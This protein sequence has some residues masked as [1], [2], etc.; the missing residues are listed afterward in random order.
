MSLSDLVCFKVAS[1]LLI[2]VIARV[3]QSTLL[4]SLSGWCS[5][6][7]YVLG[8]HM[9]FASY[10]TEANALQHVAPADCKVA[11][12]CQALDCC[13]QSGHHNCCLLGV[14]ANHNLNICCILAIVNACL[15]VARLW[16]LPN[17]LRIAISIRT[18]L[19]LVVPHAYMLLQ[20]LQAC[21][22]VATISYMLLQARQE[23]FGYKGTRWSHVSYLLL[24]ICSGG[25]LCLA[26]I[27][28]PQTQVWFLSQ[29]P[30]SEAE[31]VLV[32]VLPA[33]KVVFH[34]ADVRQ[35][36]CHKALHC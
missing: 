4:P 8:Y 31:H 32:K 16:M 5:A 14:C 6:P 27:V 11:P 34:S 30:L 24:L 10:H 35:Q 3:A 2:E 22:Y 12:I 9:Q 15:P 19:N 29:C 7:G 17:H 1:E 21:M 23:Y 33:A 36:A 25:M 26:Y 13:K 18:A 28:C 20:A